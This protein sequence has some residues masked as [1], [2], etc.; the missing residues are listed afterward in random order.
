LAGPTAIQI[1]VG[2]SNAATSADVE[3]ATT[4]S[5]EIAVYMCFANDKPP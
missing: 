3:M 1:I 2:Q 4:A 5:L